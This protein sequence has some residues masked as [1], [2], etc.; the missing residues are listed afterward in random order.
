MNAGR[1]GGVGKH[2]CTFCQSSGQYAK[3]SIPSQTCVP[4]LKSFPQ[5]LQRRWSRCHCI[6][7]AAMWSPM[8]GSPHAPH[9][10]GT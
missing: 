1:G 7:K 4:S 9:V 10:P 2:G 5:M 3:P 8:I 6:I